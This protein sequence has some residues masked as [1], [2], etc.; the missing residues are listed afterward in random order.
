MMNLLLTKKQRLIRKWLQRAE[1]R[2]K[3]AEEWRARGMDIRA[4]IAQVMA[5]VWRLSAAEL[6]KL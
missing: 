2:E 4:D 6:E 5:D 3:A 1:E